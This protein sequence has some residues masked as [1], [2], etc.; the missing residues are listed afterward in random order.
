MYTAK[1]NGILFAGEN[2]DFKEKYTRN[3]FKFKY[4]GCFNSIIAKNYWN[5]Y[6]NNDV[7]CFLKANTTLEELIKIIHCLNCDKIQINN[8]RKYCYNCQYYCNKI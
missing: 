2:K 7:Y 5:H 6:I 3:K 1:G 8:W 4:G